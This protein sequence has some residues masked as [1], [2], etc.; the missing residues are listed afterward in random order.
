MTDLEK[1]KA[2]L[3]GFG[4][5]FEVI[6]PEDEWQRQCIVV[7]CECGEEKVDGY[8]G[9]FTEFAFEMDGRFIEMGAWE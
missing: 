5:G 2:L 8:P 9:F 6:A 7:H 4:V 1:L 3:T